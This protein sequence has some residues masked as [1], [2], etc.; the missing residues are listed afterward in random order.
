M[1]LGLQIMTF[2][3]TCK[4]IKCCCAASVIVVHVGR[5]SENTCDLSDPGQKP[6]IRPD[7]QD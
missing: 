2:I 3:G 1:T 6:A 5:W 7:F 4:L